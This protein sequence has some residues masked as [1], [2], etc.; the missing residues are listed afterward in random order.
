M[1]SKLGIYGNKQMI[2]YITFFFHVNTMHKAELQ[3]KT[4]MEWSKYLLLIS[5]PSK[6]MEFLF[7]ILI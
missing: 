5:L 7:M 1:T 3:F 6:Y 4:H 2:L